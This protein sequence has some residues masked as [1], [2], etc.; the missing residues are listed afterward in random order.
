VGPETQCCWDYGVSSTVIRS[1]RGFDCWPA[2]SCLTTSGSILGGAAL[3]PCIETSLI[4]T[5][6]QAAEK[7][8]FATNRCYSG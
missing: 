1:D 3:Q 2:I 8:A 6:D 7:R 4:N 5:A